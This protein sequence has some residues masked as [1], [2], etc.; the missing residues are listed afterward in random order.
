MSVS[1]CRADAV[2][3]ISSNVTPSDLASL[4]AYDR[5]VSPVAKP[6][7]ENAWMSL[8]GRPS[9]SI[10]RALT[11]SAWVES[12]PPLMPMTAFGSPMYVS[13]CSRPQTWML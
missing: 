9:R 4:L 2:M 6:G 10:A 12:S 11:I 5:V 7:I 13:R 1:I 3:S 8:R